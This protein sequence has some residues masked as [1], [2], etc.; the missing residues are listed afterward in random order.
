M[1]DDGLAV[2]GGRHGKV[3]DMETEPFSIRFRIDNAPASLPR[4]DSLR[5]HSIQ[6]VRS[7]GRRLT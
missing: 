3:V 2:R 6:P 5:A 7:S 1:V 4:Q